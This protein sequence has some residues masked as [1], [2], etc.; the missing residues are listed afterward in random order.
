[1]YRTAKVDISRHG[2]NRP[3]KRAAGDRVRHHRGQEKEVLV[4]TGVDRIFDLKER[5]RSVKVRLG[6][7]FVTGGER[8]CGEQHEGAAFHVASSV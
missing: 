2:F 8:E 6:G 5:R 3:V 4:A 7:S 1:M